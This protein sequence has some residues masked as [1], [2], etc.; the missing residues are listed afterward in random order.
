MAH[1]MGMKVPGLRRLREKAVL[2]QGELAEKMGVSRDSVCGWET[3]RHGVRFRR[4][5]VLAEIL[6][7]TPQELMRGDDG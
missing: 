4:L 5:K 2:D 7:C 6:G 1:N 3:G